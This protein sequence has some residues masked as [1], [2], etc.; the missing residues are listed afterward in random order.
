MEGLRG[1]PPS[2]KLLSI[3]HRTADFL[4]KVGGFFFDK[5]YQ[6]RKKESTAL[7]LCEYSQAKG[8]FLTT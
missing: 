7:C 1:Q 3:I 8:G 5:V 2:A 6:F 4:C